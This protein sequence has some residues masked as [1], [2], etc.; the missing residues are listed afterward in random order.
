MTLGGGEQ[1]GDDHDARVHRPALERVVEV[2][3]MSC[4]SVHERG[5]GRVQ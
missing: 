5:T 1:R 3:S 4:S 2:L